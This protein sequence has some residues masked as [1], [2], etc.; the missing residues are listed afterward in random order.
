MLSKTEQQELNAAIK[1]LL[2]RAERN[3]GLAKSRNLTAQQKELIR[4]AEVFVNQAQSARETDLNA[5]KSL[6]ERAELLSREALR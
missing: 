3:L 4:Q 5:A 6:A 1:D 2:E